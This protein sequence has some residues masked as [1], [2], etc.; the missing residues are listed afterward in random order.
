[1]TTGGDNK[2]GRV[3]AGIAATALG[4]ALVLA[5]WCWSG[6]SLHDFLSVAMYSVGWALLTFCAFY[7]LTGRF[8]AMKWRRKDHD[9]VDRFEAGL[10][11]EGAARTK[12]S[13]S[14]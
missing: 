9:L 8:D 11:D 4:A 10:T 3:P 7:F 12:G 1:M 13:E 14:Q 2:D 6:D 5:A